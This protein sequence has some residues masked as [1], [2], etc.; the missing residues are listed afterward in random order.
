M[1]TQLDPDFTGLPGIK[2]VLYEKEK[3]SLWQIFYSMVRGLTKFKT[4]MSLWEE[5]DG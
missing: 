5:Y 2:P 4:H 1:L 3:F